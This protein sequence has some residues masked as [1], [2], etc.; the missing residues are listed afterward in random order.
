MSPSLHC[1]GALALEVSAGQAPGR[2][3]LPRDEAEAL[4]GDL[5]LDL[6]RLL[7]GVQ[8]LDGVFAGAHFDP[9]EVLRPGWPVHVALADLAARVPG[10]GGGRLIVFGAQDER[11][12]TPALQ[13]DPA[14]V[15][16]LL[17]VLP[18]ALLGDP[19]QVAAVGQAMEARL[20]DTGMAAAAT[21][22][23]AQSRF[24]LVLEHARFLSLHDLCA[25]TAMQY[26][27]AGIGGA[28][29][30]VE[31][32]LL[33]P[34]S[35]EWLREPGEPP[36]CLGKGRVRIGELELAAWRESLTPGDRADE[37]AFAAFRRRTRQLMAVLGAHGLAIDAVP[38]A[39]GQDVVAAL[40]PQY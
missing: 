24:G 18:F 11:M 2:L 40:G 31:A 1:L 30:L 33:A 21:A 28:W 37:A 13:P 6:Q 38:I 7:P 8:A 15:G 25:M 4:A 9:A 32:A 27:N 29:R 23:Q 14:F 10:E 34:Q 3:M 22:L 12:P 26:E 35:P 19:E 16:G 36:A 5:A 39:A 17:R 20:L